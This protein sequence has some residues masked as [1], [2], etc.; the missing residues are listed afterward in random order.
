[1]GIWFG[2]ALLVSL[3]IVTQGFSDEPDYRVKH[4]CD[5]ARSG[6]SV[7]E[8]CRR[9]DLCLATFYNW[10][11]LPHE[12]GRKRVHAGSVS[13]TEV[14]RVVGQAQWAAEITLRSGVVV[15]VSTAADAQLLRAVVEVLG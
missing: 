1:L 6:L 8:Y 2:G 14:G 5:Q 10:R 4:V 3:N 13:F 9:H 12:Y 15:R 11:R 7:A